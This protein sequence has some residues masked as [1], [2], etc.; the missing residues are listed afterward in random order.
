[1][2]DEYSFFKIGG[3]SYPAQLRASTG[4]TA[5]VDL[6]PFRHE[7]MTFVKGVLEIDLGERYAEEAADCGLTQAPDIVG[8]SLPYDPEPYLTNTGLVFPVLAVYPLRAARSEH[9]RLRERITRTVALV[10][11]LPPLTAAQAEAM[12][13]FLDAAADVIE[14]RI[15]QGYDPD[16]ESGRL[17]FNSLHLD[18]INVTSVTY[19]RMMGTGTVRGDKLGAHF[20]TV[21]VIVEVAAVREDVNFESGLE[22]IDAQVAVKDGTGETIMVEFS[23]ETSA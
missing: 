11:V 18:R 20:P 7:L 10:Y 22:G 2:T 19:G 4:K 8:S 15:D 13:P 3:V 1:V 5:L 14:N 21:E 9:S 12:T 16:H 23:Q 6:A 17:V